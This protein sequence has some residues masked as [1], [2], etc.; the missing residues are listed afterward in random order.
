MFWKL[1]VP[2]ILAWTLCISMETKKSRLRGSIPSPY[3]LQGN[4]LSSSQQP[5]PRRPE[6]KHEVLSSSHE[7]LVVTER[8][9]LR[10]DWC[11]TQPL[12]QTVGME[13]CVSRTVLNRFCYGQCNSFY[14]PRAQPRPHAQPRPRHGRKPAPGPKHDAPFQS[15]G[16]CRPHRIT[17]VTVRLRCPGLRPPYRHRKVQRVKQCRCV[18]VSVSDAY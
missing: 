12:R 15:C 8:K 14:I 9:Y 13:G 6:V 5:L 4:E 11:K 16:F 2:A 17:T 7:A 3:K 1:A 10:S 18:A